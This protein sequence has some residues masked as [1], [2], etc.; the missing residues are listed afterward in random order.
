[1]NI[2]YMTIKPGSILLQKDYSWLTRIWY[3]LIG[4]KLKF[5]AFTIFTN[6]C[7]LVNVHGERSESIVVEPKKAYSK[8]ELKRLNTIINDSKKEDGDWLSSN[9]ATILDLFT[10]INCV[11]PDTIEDS[12]ELDALLSNKYYITKK[13]SDEANWNEYIF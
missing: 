7:D 6:D 13:L 3:K 11:R 9:K 12:K 4:K 10:A 2:E 1:M 5:N 8:K